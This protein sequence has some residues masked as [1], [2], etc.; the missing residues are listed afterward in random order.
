[1]PHLRIALL[2]VAAL[3]FVLPLAIP[4]AFAQHFHPPQHADLH[5]TF[6]SN[7]MRPDQP[8]VSCCNKME[9]GGS[10]F[11]FIAGAGG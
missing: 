4:R 2:G 11:C 3:G 8:T 10:V 9:L 6:Y 1:M 7:W 5:D